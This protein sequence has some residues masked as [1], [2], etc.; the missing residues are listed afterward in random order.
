MQEYP[1]IFENISTIGLLMPEHLAQERTVS[2]GS[3][4]C[5]VQ[6]EVQCGEKTCM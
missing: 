1:P 3:R 6:G 4:H 2:V 5:T